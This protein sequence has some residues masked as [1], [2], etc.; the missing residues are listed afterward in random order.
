MERSRLEQGKEPGSNI[1]CAAG[2]LSP[3]ATNR[4]AEAGGLAG[5]EM[6]AL[7]VGMSAG[8]RGRI[9]YGNFVKLIGPVGVVMVSTACRPIHVVDGTRTSSGKRT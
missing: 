5:S 6:A 1:L 4:S 9:G 8:H 2:R 7:G 3:K